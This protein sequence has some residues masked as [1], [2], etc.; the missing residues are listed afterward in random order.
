MITGTKAGMTPI[1]RLWRLRLRRLFP[2]H[3]RLN[4]LA[5]FA[6]IVTMFPA[7]VSFGAAACQ[8]PVQA[9]S[10]S[11]PSH[12]IVPHSPAP[13]IVHQSAQPLAAASV[14]ID[15]D[16]TAASTELLAVFSSAGLVPAACR[17]KLMLMLLSMGIGS[18]RAL[19]AALSRDPAF[20]EQV[21]LVAVIR[22]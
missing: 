6:M 5:L 9:S 8:Q 11:Q 15:A 13:L 20:L 10:N 16:D 4:N 14:T 18:E 22:I 3:V 12:S 17:Q 19:V 1:W 21:M 2:S 7:D